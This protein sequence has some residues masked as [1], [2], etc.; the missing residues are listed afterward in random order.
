MSLFPSRRSIE[1]PTYP[2]T[3][4][5]LL[6]LLGLPSTD[7][8]IKVTEENSLTM[9]TVYRSVAL[10]SGLGGA[11]PMHV[12]A[13]GTRDKIENDLLLNPHPDMTAYEFWKLSF[14]HR[15]LWGNFYAQKM[16]NGAGQLTELHPIRPDRV[17]VGRAKPIEGNKSGKIFRV[18][19]DSGHIHEFNDRTIL[20]IPGLGYDGVCGVSPVR[21]AAQGIGLAI[22]AESY[23]AKLFGNGNLMSGILQTEQRLDQEQAE[24]LQRRW[25]EKMGGLDRAHTVAVL[26]SGA[27]FQSLTMP[28]DDAQL[29][30]SRRFQIS[31]IARYFGVPPYLLMETEKDTSWGTGLEAQA[32]GFIQFDLYPQWLAPTE[33]RITKE[34]LAEGAYAKYN[35]DGLLRGD[36]QSRAEFYK[37]MREVGAYSANDIRELEDRPPIPD[38]DTYLQPTTL[39]P[40]G[41]DVSKLKKDSEGKGNASQ[42]SA[43]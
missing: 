40:L 23:A 13:K 31:E 15:T 24:T 33:Q 7:A 38:G 35:V 10:I 36:A 9:S 37:V 19:D 8:G 1:A 11:L 2:L 26:D 28:N 30:E 17:K 41:T 16:R 6:S 21:M 20:H 3:S 22:A 39:V 34:L 18:E 25:Q 14:V 29:L 32:T 12:Y 4:A 27:A 43:Q 5:S 42:P